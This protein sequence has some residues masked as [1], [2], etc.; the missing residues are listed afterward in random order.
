MERWEKMSNKTIISKDR[1]ECLKTI[2]VSAL[3]IKIQL[4][5][6]DIYLLRQKADK[7]D[8]IK[9]IWNSH[10]TEE[11]DVIQYIDKILNGDK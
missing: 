2:D 6:H 8:E 7:Y 5:E 9:S 11:R 1:T 3:A 4:L 10:E